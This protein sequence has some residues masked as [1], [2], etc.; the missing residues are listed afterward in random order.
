MKFPSQLIPV[1]LATRAHTLHHV[2]LGLLQHVV[3]VAGRASHVHTVEIKAGDMIRGRAGF[4]LW[5]VY[6]VEL[7]R[8]LLR[9]PV[10]PDEPNVA[11]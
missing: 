3:S 10:W 9:S 7:S 11:G 5:D 6:A 8:T 2:V 4:L 1:F